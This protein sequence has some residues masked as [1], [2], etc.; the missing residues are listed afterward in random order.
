MTTSF[1]NHGIRRDADKYVVQPTYQCRRTES[2]VSLEIGVC[3]C[4]KCKYFLITEVEKKH[5]RRRARFQQ[6]RDPNCHQ[7]SFF[8]ARQGAE[9]IHAILKE[10][11]GEHAPLYST[12]KKWVAQ[13]KSGDFL[14]EMRLDLDDPNIDKP[15]DY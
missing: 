12:V 13:F 11:L 3:S 9:E 4:T 1:S 2:I 8:L 10:T 5:V 15:G 14:P 7:V 6:H